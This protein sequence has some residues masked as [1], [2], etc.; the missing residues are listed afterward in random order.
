MLQAIIDINQ[1]DINQKNNTLLIRNHVDYF[2]VKLVSILSYSSTTI[3]AFAT[4][5]HFTKFLLSIDT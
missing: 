1:V 5:S 3:S 4:P 2:K